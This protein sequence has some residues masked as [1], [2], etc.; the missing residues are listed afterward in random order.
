[1]TGDHL[2]AAPDSAF[3][4]LF[5]LS[6]RPLVQLPERGAGIL[7]TCTTCEHE[8]W[9][10]GRDL[11]RLFPNWL[12]KDVWLWAKAMKC[13][14]CPSVRQTFAAKKDG[15]AQGFSKG[16]GDP[17]DAQYVRRLMTWLPE[18]GRQIDDVAY[19]VR[20]VDAP[21]LREAGFPDDIVALFAGGTCS[22]DHFYPTDQTTQDMGSR[23]QKTTK[24]ATL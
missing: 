4:M 24:A 7:Q 3:P 19:L 22:S 5:G 13:E 21:T 14:N 18:G 15:A 23:A 17:T 20:D 8:I 2:Q 16:P 1:M 12:T 11:C 6:H 10:G 9:F